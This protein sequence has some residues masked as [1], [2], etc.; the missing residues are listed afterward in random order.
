MLSFLIVSI[1]FCLLILLSEYFIITSIS[2]ITDKI[3]INIPVIGRLYITLLIPIFIDKY[4]MYD[5][6]IPIGIPINNDLEQVI[7][8]SKN[9]IFK[10]LIDNLVIER[11]GSDKT[12]YWRILK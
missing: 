3:L 6:N 4:I 5:K 12:G 8:L 2:T 1:I 10:I 9:I 7:I 11:I